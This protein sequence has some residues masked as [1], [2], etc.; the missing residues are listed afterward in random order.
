MNGVQ[1][2][3]IAGQGRGLLATQTIKKG[4]VVLSIPLDA[5]VTPQTAAQ[6]SVLRDVITSSNSNGGDDDDD[7]LL[8]ERRTP[9]PDWTL[10]A[11]WL[12]E[13]LS[14]PE[15]TSPS[16]DHA[17][18]AAYAAVL[19]KEQSIGNVLEWTNEQ[20]NWLIGSEL[21]TKAIEIRTAAEN[22]WKELQPIIH[23]AESS[24]LI[25][26]GV[27][28]ESGVKHAF[29]LLLSRLIRVSFN[30]SAGTTNGGGNVNLNNGFRGENEVEVLCPLADFVN[31]DSS[32]TSFLQL[33]QKN[34]NIVL[35][36]DRKYLTG[37]QVFASY[38]QKTQGELLLS[39]GFVPEEGSNPHDA[40]LLSIHD[41]GKEGEG[42]KVFPLRMGAVP[43]SLLEALSSADLEKKTT[44]SE[45]LLVD[46]CKKK[47]E[48]YTV[49]LETAKTEL[50]NLSSSGGNGSSGKETTKKS[51]FNVARREA[52]LRILVQEQKILA[53]T[54]FLMKQQLKQ[55]ST[56]K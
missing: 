4:T 27:L 2:S 21:Y 55:T 8:Q 22:S 14:N 1:C 28:T 51:L 45:Q 29:A 52:V 24:G 32:C 6:M 37:E 18:H 12:A 33:D 9:L 34:E 47:L 10:L 41:Q 50:L 16:S 42:G 19:P 43:Q 15:D 49:D 53:R 38:G 56:R 35:V 7:D 30:T 54:I 17:V 44:R 31:H 48:K 3:D 11:V 46:L 5:A 36:S 23:T 13:L 25:T 20:V 39:Y 26:K 40:C